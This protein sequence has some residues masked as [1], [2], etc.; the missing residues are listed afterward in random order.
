MILTPRGRPLLQGEHHGHGGYSSSDGEAESADETEAA[1]VA[2]EML[3]PLGD[4]RELQTG[5]KRESLAAVLASALRAATATSHATPQRESPEWR[6]SPYPG[7]SSG[8]GGAGGGEQPARA[9]THAHTH[10]HT[11]PAALHARKSPHARVLRLPARCAYGLTAWLRRWLPQI[12]ARARARA[13][14]AA[15]IARGVCFRLC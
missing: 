6:T 3:P 13:H 11:A 15:R 10:T 9:G 1:S 12:R 5:G 4:G 2:R 8:L 14:P 7:S